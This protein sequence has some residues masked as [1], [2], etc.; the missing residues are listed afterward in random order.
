MSILL[1]VIGIIWALLGFLSIIIIFVK[2]SSQNVLTYG[3]IINILLFV[4]PGLILYGVGAKINKKDKSKKNKIKYS[5][6]SDETSVE[7][8]LTK[9]NQLKEE[10]LINDTE[11]ESKR[12]E[13]LKKL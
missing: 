1:Q 8:R 4:I 13:I 7:E 12:T 2:Q 3:L 6:E 9:L 5:K 11:Y 10:N